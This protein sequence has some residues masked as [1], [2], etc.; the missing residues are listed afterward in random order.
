MLFENHQD[1][2]QQLVQ[3]A[4]GMRGEIRDMKSAIGR[5]LTLANQD[6]AG[7]AATIQELRDIL[8]HQAAEIRGARH[9]ENELQSKIQET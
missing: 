1:V 6:Q 3:E 7:Q 4:H 8:A 2:I 9:F 5:A